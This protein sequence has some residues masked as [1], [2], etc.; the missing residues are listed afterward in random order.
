MDMEH[1][2]KQ[3]DLSKPTFVLL[4]GTGGD[5]HDL[6]P[7]AELLDPTY[8]ALGVRGN[9]SENGMNRFFKRHGE[10]QYDVEDLKF[11]TT[12]LHEFLQEAAQRYQFDLNEVILVGF[13]NGSNIAISLML[14]EA[15]PY[16]KGLL[17]AP[18]YPLE[19]PKD[20]DLSD[21]SVYLSM[22][23]NDPIV[24]ISESEHVRSIFKDRGAEVTEFWVNSH[25]L[26][27]ETV[28]AAKATL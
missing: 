14:N 17:F 9:I 11:R 28:E 21:K 25:E 3:G 24:P 18:L 4:H 8:N 13:S 15:M 23:K 20:I 26:T 16:K 2:F 22:G 5:E 1:I 10:G 12:E 7:I 27:R 19:V 6:L